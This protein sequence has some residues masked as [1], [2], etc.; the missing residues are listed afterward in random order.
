MSFY[1]DGACWN[2]NCQAGFS[3]VHDSTFGVV[4]FSNTSTGDYTKIYWNF[5]NGANSELPNLTIIYDTTFDNTYEVCI[6]VFDS[7]LNCYDKFCDTIRIEQSISNCGLVVDF[8]YSI[9][10]DT[11]RF[12][13]I[14]SQVIAYFWDFGDGT[15]ST[16]TQPW[17]VF[18][19][20]GTYDVCLYITDEFNCMD[21]ICRQIHYIK[22]G[23]IQKKDLDYVSLSVYPNPAKQKTS[24][25]YH[26]P[27]AVEVQIVL[28]DILG[29]VVFKIDEIP[30]TPGDHS[31]LWNANRVPAGVYYVQLR[32]GEKWLTQRLS[33][34]K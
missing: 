2:G 17:H 30:G 12:N 29:N 14:S 13:N 33:I 19:S 25:H 26:L 5:G 1:N 6:T 22:S 8:N 32:T 9:E 28:F 21:S 18:S 27:T 15:S 10:E 4:H 11:V 7:A 3:A 24:F 34:I 20:T 31:L 16:V 23:I